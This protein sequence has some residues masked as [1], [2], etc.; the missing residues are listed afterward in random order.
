MVAMLGR[1]RP[2]DQAERAR[3][4]EYAGDA[5]S[6]FE[7]MIAAAQTV[8]NAELQAD[9]IYELMDPKIA[10][11][12]PR[13]ARIAYIQATSHHPDIFILSAPMLTDPFEIRNGKLGTRNRTNT[14]DTYNMLS[15]VAGFIPGDKAVAVTN[16]HFTPFQGADAAGQLASFGV[17][18]EVVGFDPNHF[19]NPAKKSN[20][21]LQE[22]LTAAESLAKAA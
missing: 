22:M 16:A 3:A 13:H 7:L 21:L 12:L 19:G 2:V 5:A 4:G 10:D 8:F 20:E 18:T 14:R 6:E 15:K 9:D 17:E 1:D 11:N